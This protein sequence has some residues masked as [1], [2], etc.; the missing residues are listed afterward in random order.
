MNIKEIQAVVQ[1]KF[2]F[3]I[4]TEIYNFDYLHTS[5]SA[6]NGIVITGT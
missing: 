5:T 2:D 4:S 1:I 3:G 6:N